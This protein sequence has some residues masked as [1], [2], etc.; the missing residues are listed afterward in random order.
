[1]PETISSS[2]VPVTTVFTEPE[3][4]ALAGFV[5]GYSGQTRGAYTLDL[6]QYAT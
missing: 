4:L 1:M 5:A 6:R 3:R 2:T